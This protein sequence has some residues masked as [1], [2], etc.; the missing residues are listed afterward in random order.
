MKYFVKLKRIY[1]QMT[2]IIFYDME[3]GRD[4]K[5]KNLLRKKLANR[6]Q[7]NHFLFI[8]NLRLGFLSKLI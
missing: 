6:Y 5:S 7:S 2:Y 8:P 3:N 1:S 4:F